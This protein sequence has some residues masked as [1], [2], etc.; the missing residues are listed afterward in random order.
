MKQMN[1]GVAFAFCA[2]AALGAWAKNAKDVAHEFLYE[3][4]PAGWMTAEPTVRKVADNDRFVRSVR[5]WTSPDGRLVLRSTKTDYKRFPAVEYLPELICRG[6]AD[7][8][9][10]ADFHSLALTSP[11]K[12]FVVRALK[13]TKA[14]ERDFEAVHFRL[15]EGGEKAVALT[16]DEG[17]S[18]AEWMPW[19]NV[20]FADGS[21]LVC[22]VGWTG[23]W[24]ADFAQG[25][26]TMKMT[27]GMVK[28][29]FRLHPGETLRQPSVLVFRRE[30]AVSPRAMLTLVHRF[31][32]DEKCPR[33]VRGELVKP[34]LPITAGGGNKTPE[35]MRKGELRSAIIG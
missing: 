6:S 5:E 30:K 27:A 13:G 4:V 21:G 7:T 9:I 16:T 10:V 24:R 32:L 14:T 28:T 8:G 26:G 3:G 31:M 25:D 20:D 15:G 2:F 1:R 34:L 11:G 29:H 33:N 12:S 17:R 18:S 23:A 22:A 19:W 35:M